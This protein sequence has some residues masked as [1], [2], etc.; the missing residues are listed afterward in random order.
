MGIFGVRDR[1]L[2]KI[3]AENNRRTELYKLTDTVWIQIK[4]R[5]WYGLL[6][7]SVRVMTVMT[8]CIFG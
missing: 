2:M 4:V 3:D 8:S 1:Q 5:S 7:T 6:S